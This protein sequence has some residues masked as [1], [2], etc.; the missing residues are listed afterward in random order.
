ML[1]GVQLHAQIN[2]FSVVDGELIWQRVYDTDRTRDDVLAAIV[3][4]GRFSDVTEA[5][6]TITC[7]LVPTDVDASSM[8]YDPFYLPT[9][10][11]NADITAFVTVQV[12]EGRYRVTLERFTLISTFDGVH[13]LGDRYPLGP[14]ATKNGQL[15]KSFTK[16]AC[17]VYDI[18]FS[19]CFSLQ[20]KS[21]LDDEW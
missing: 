14:L 9:Y 10:L 5:G 16:E 12:K 20:T 18:L 2:N 21:Y 8:G 6:G 7:F 17:E 19:E 11:S 1:L 4:D 15:S 13:R 3:N